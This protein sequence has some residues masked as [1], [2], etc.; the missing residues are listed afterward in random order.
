VRHVLLRGGFRPWFD[1]QG[2]PEAG[3]T[4]PTSGDSFRLFAVNVPGDQPLAKIEVLAT[5]TRWNGVPDDAP[6]L[7]TRE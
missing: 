3:A 5:P 2:Q 4:D 6:V 7:L 1:P